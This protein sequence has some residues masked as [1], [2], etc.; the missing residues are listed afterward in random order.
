MTNTEK[1]AK[2]IL[3][4]GDL[5]KEGYSLQDLFRIRDGL[6]ILGIYGLA[7]LDLLTEVNKYIQQKVGSND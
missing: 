5:E 7:D 3:E 4:G 2:R 6:E 1:L